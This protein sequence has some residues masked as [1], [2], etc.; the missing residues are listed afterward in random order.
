LT[1]S[2]SAPDVRHEIADGGGLSLAQVASRFPSYRRGKP[3]TASAVWR[4]VSEG[5]K[6]PSGLVRLEAARV[7]GRWLTSES[8]LRRFI[9]AQSTPVSE[10]PP[11][12]A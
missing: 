5:V 2:L 8:A 6:T 9:A 7:A 1:T 12:A 11:D 3:V 10:G 4:W